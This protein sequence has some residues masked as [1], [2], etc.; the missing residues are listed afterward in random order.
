MS[1][2]INL[3]GG[4]PSDPYLVA[5]NIKKGVTVLGVTGTLGPTVSLTEAQYR[6]LASKDADTLYLITAVN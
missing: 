3:A 1:A 4:S 5:E 2:V 6:A